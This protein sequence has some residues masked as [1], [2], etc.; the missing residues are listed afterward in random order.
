MEEAGAPRALLVLLGALALV[1]GGD[2]LLYLPQL[3][4][5]G[6]YFSFYAPSLAFFLF[7]TAS[8]ALVPICI[9][10]GIYHLAKGAGS[11]GWGWATLGLAWGISVALLASILSPEL[12]MDGWVQAPLWFILGALFLLLLPLPWSRARA[13]TLIPVLG[14]VA[15]SLFVRLNP[16][17]S[18]VAPPI[19]DWGPFWMALFA[20]ELAGLVWLV[21]IR[22]RYA[23]AARLS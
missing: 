2:W 16:E 7:V 4:E 15:L 1:L 12:I 5:A 19:T 6:A 20:I 9:A 21:V 11:R 13:W 22:P 10:V 8:G 23:D 18:Y 14:L 17:A 3:P